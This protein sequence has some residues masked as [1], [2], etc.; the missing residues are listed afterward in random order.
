VAKNPKVKQHY[1]K[2]HVVTKID[3]WPMCTRSQAEKEKLPPTFTTC[4]KTKW[5]TCKMYK[6]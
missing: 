3:K 4:N 6:F 2:Q 5:C 1:K